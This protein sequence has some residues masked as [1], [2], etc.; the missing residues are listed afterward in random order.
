MNFMEY[1]DFVK[2]KLKEAYNKNNKDEFVRLLEVLQET[3][4][5]K[6]RELTK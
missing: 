1:M 2:E 5:E 6:I 4:T 3:T